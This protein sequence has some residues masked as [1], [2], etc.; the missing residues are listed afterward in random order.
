MESQL[1]SRAEQIGVVKYGDFTL[2]SGLRS[3]YYVDGR[4]LSLDGRGSALIGQIINK[5]LP[6]GTMSVGGPA[7]GSVPLVVA[8][9]MTANSQQRD[10][11]GFYVRSSVKEHGRQQLVEGVLASPAVIVDD[12][13]TTGGSVLQVAA[14]LESRGIKVSLI[15]S[16]F[17]RGARQNIGGKGYRYSAILFINGDKL[18]IY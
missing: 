4:L 11:Q 13:C 5:R 2:S 1:L 9:V 12:A 7:V 6:D 18:S 8:T 15:I 17:D 14:E 3:K 16:V 10:L